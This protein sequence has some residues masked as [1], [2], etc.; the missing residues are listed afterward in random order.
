LYSSAKPTQTVFT[1]NE[2]SGRFDGVLSQITNLGTTPKDSRINGTY[3]TKHLFGTYSA[4]IQHVQGIAFLTGRR[5]ALSHDSRSD[6]RALFVADNGD[7][8]TKMLNIGSSGDHPGGLQAAGKVVVVP[9][10]D[11]KES[12]R[13]LVFMDC[14]NKN[15]PIWLT[16][17]NTTLTSNVEAAGIAFDFKRACHWVI[18]AGT[19]SYGKSGVSVYKSNGKSLFDPACRFTYQGSISGGFASQGGTQIHFDTNGTMYVVGLYRVEPEGEKNLGRS[20]SGSGFTA[21]SEGTEMIGVSEITNLDSSPFAPVGILKLDKKLS[22][23]GQWYDYGAGFRWGGTI[24]KGP[25]GKL[26][27]VGVSRTLTYGPAQRYARIRV[28]SQ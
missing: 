21:T 13:E 24:A 8:D 19:Y 16:H 9:I 2:H 11:T 3:S 26:K 14:R 10:K 25:D 15:A 1:G 20:K 28:W 12:T 7:N 17:L 4:G 27:A 18:T 5:Y 23:S 22:D 6:R